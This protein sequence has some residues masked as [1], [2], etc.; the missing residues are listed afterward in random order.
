MSAWLDR[1]GQYPT[2]GPAVTQSGLVLGELNWP[3]TL[4]LQEVLVLRG[5]QGAQQRPGWELHTRKGGTNQPEEQT[6][7]PGGREGGGAGVAWRARGGLPSG[8]G[9][10]AAPAGRDS[11]AKGRGDGVFIQPVPKFKV[12]RKSLSIEGEKMGV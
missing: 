6:Q 11:L 7:R 5:N 2:P 10:D 4:V 9:S 1:P 12:R 8:G 3:G